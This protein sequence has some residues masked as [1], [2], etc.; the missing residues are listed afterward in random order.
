MFLVINKIIFFLPRQFYT[1]EKMSLLKVDHI[2]IPPHNDV[3]LI[4]SRFI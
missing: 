2:E 4:N 1:I 3:L